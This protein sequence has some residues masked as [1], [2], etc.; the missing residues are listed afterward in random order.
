M[1]DERYNTADYAYGKKPNEFLAG[2]ISKI[3]PGRVLCIAEGEGRNA[4]FLAEH[5]RD[6]VAVDAS[7]VGLKKARK[8]AGER[9]VHIQTVNADLAHFD[10]EPDSWD[11]VISIFAHVPPGT[12]KPLHNRIVR[13]LRSGGMLVLEAYTPEQLKLG[14]GGPA[15]I[16]MTMSLKALKEELDGLVFKHAVE[17][18]RDVIE[19]S[20]HTGTG[21][22]VQ[23]IAVKP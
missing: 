4:V 18:R 1:W 10:I 14:T 22:V 6:V 17:L 20:Y 19:G 11:A 5:G 16:E 21:A 7:V 23:L 2:V 15:D 9:G 8:L 13:G 3:P 12:R